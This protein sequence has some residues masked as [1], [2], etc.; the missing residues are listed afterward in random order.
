MTY[1]FETTINNILSDLEI[2]F[3]V[4]SLQK[5]C[6]EKLANKSDACFAK[7]DAGWQ[8]ARKE[9]LALLSLSRP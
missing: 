4:K 8:Y 2:E 6:L 9:T 5:V 3:K 7:I 1:I